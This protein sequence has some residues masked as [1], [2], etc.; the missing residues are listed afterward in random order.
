MSWAVKELTDK[1]MTASAGLKNLAA[2]STTVELRAA[3]NFEEP[4]RNLLKQL[5]LS[6]KNVT[7]AEVVERLYLKTGATTPIPDNIKTNTHLLGKS[8]LGAAALS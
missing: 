7:V 2:N 3:E 5:K 4:Y 6:G 8:M 1:G